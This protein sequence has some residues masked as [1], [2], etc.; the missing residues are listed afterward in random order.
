VQQ[1]LAIE[2]WMKLVV[3][4]LSRITLDGNPHEAV[5]RLLHDAANYQRL[6]RRDLVLERDA[7]REERQTAHEEATLAHLLD[8]KLLARSS[9][10][11]RLQISMDDVIS[12]GR[13]LVRRDLLGHELTRYAIA[14]SDC[15]A[16][17]VA[18]LGLGR[19]VFKS[20][21]TAEKVRH[22]IRR[23]V[24]RQ[25]ICLGGRSQARRTAVWTSRF[26]VDRIAAGE[27]DFFSGLVE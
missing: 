22:R 25:L 1:P 9:H 5:P 20:S 18:H 21:E 15:A 14:L 11:I 19:V 12:V 27:I 17:E 4:V 26:G 6:V 10:A 13:R 7:V 16:R 3:E 23:P 24:S 8:P 2:E